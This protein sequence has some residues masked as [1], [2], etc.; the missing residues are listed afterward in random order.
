MREFLQKQE[1]PYGSFFARTS[2][3]KSHFWKICFIDRDE[4]LASFSTLY[5]ISEE[6]GDL[7]L[8]LSGHR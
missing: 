6:S 3:K 4:Y 7:A 2:L 5:S 8:S 1:S